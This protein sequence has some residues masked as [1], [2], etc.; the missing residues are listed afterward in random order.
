MRN[1]FSDILYEIA[2]QDPRVYVV[3]SD[4]SPAGSMA[5]FREEFPDRF[6]NTGVAEQAMIGICAGLAREGAIPFAYTIAAFSI[7][8]PYEFIRDDIALANLNVNIVGIGAGLVYSTLG[9]TH[10]TIEDVGIMSMLPNMK[11]FSP[12]DTNEVRAGMKILMSESSN[13]NHPTYIRLGK[14]GE[15]ELPLKENIQDIESKGFRFIRKNLNSEVLF[16]SYGLC[17][18]HVLKLSETLVN[19][20]QINSDVIS[21]PMVNTWNVDAI[22]ETFSKY[23]YIAIIEE[24]L[25]IGSLGAQLELTFSKQIPNVQFIRFNLGGNFVN[26]YGQFEDLTQGTNISL[27]H[28][29][30]SLDQIIK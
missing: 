20:K 12:G 18:H 11:I 29:L 27:N 21:M 24:H 23:R 8:R 25:D 7:L 19:L 5:K 26:G 28:M 10:H 6:I 13:R 30:T 14:A 17:V 2:T 3:V 9:P 22:L 15:P 1:T 4:I 16:L